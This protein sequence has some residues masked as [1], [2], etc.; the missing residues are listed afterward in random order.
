MCT[1][2]LYYN[3]HINLLH[4]GA[5]ILSIIAPYF[6]DQHSLKV[7]LAGFMLLTS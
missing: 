1:S 5:P 3:S 7:I 6:S 2:K 4:I